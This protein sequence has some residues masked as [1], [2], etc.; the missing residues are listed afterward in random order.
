M[1]F[2]QNCTT[3]RPHRK[4]QS[5]SCVETHRALT[6]LIRL[7][8]FQT[9]PNESKRLQATYADE[10]TQA[11]LNFKSVVKGLNL[12]LVEQ[13]LI[14]VRGRLTKLNVPFDTRCPILLP[15]DHRLKCLCIVLG[16]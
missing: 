15:A 9:F 7:A 8:Q 13:G 10:L 4:L 16:P 2:A 12:F 14:R 1:R 3:S 11:E 5:L 6:L